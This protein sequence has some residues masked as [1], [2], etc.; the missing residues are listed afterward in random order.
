MSVLRPIWA[1][2]FSCHVY[3]RNNIL[4]FTA[5][6]FVGIGS[7][8]KCSG[9]MI[10][11]R[12]CK[13]VFYV[14]KW[15]LWLCDTQQTMLNCYNLHAIATITIR[16]ISHFNLNTVHSDN[17]VSYTSQQTSSNMH[18]T[19]K[20]SESWY[21][22]VSRSFVSSW[23]PFKSNHVF[24]KL[25]FSSYSFPVYGNWF[26]PNCSSQSSGCIKQQDLSLCVLETTNCWNS[27]NF[28][29]RVHNAE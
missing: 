25:Y 20:L 9:I 24:L 7:N 3:P 29:A 8:W 6:S 11:V 27:D 2:Y 5:T 10:P 23:R 4:D 16:V 15:H 14:S 21:S 22:G 1:A 26:L 28:P 18:H 17:D 12:R 19:K 13:Q